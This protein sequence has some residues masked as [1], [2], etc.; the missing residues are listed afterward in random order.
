[1]VKMESSRIESKAA[2]EDEGVLLG[3]DF[4]SYQNI[5]AGNISLLDFQFSVFNFSLIL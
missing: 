4:C 2:Q 1:M 5:S 3:M